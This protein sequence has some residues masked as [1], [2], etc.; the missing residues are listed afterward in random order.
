MKTWLELKADKRAVTM[1]EYG[2]I[3]AVVAVVAV[4]GFGTLGSGLSTKMGG[5]ATTLSS[6]GGSSSSSSTGP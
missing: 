5:I 4:V 6:S 1:L 2:L 3:A